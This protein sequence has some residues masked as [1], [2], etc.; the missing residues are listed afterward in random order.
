MNDHPIRRVLL[1]S[2]VGLLA[3]GSAVQ[4]QEKPAGFDPLDWPNW[5]GPEQNNTSREVGLVDS[6]NPKGGDGS[7]LL[8]KR[9]DLGSRSTPIVFRGRLYTLAR[10]EPGTP[11]E[12]E[13]VACVDAATGETVWVHRF[14]VYLS[15]VPDTRVAWSSVVADAETG[16]VYAQ[17]VCGYFCC[18][19][20]ETGKVVWERSLH[21]EFGFL[22]TYGGR[23]NFPFVMEDLVVTSAV[24][25]GWDEMAKP[26]HRFVA[27][28]KKT[29]EMV[30]FNGTRLIPYDTTYSTP[31]VTVIDGQAA[32]VFG[33]GDGQVW[34]MQPRTGKHIW[35]YPFSRRGLNV[36]P[37]VHE[38]MVYTGHSEENIEGTAMG[39]LVALDGAT[40]KQLWKL[41]EVMVGK[42]SP[43]MV[44]GQL[45]TI[46]DRAKLMAFDPT[47]GE[48]IFRKP[49]GTVQRSTPLLA[50]GKLYICDNNG[51]WYVLKPEKNGVKVLQ[52]MR[53]SHQASDG[54]PI[55]S[56]GRI[57]IPLS[58]GLFCI[59]KAD[60]EPSATPR[61]EPPQETPVDQ[62]QQVVQVQVVP[63]EVLLEPGQKQQ[64]S[65]RVYNA[66]GQRLPD[67]EAT[68]TATGAGQVSEDGMFTAAADAAH[69]AAFIEAKVGDSV[70]RARIRVVPP[71]PWR[72][73]FEDLDDMPITWIGGRVRY[74]VREVD[75]QKIAVK[76]DNIPTRP[77]HFTKLGTRS[78]LWMGPITLHDYTIQADV[79][80]QRKD[81]KMP[82]IGLINQRYVMVLLGQ[83]Q[84]LQID[85]WATQLRLHT[86]IDFPCQ[87]GAWYTMKFT[88]DV[89]DGKATLRGK[90][91]PRDQKEPADWTIVAT[92]DMPNLMG[93]PGLFGNTTDAE[94]YLDN[95][96]VTRNTGSEESQ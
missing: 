46:D 56:H 53:L 12:R 43:I 65:V 42:S 39:A 75:G 68:F 38:G 58:G 94:A 71:L 14:N 66:R 80:V 87:P 15:D 35:N 88:T 3:L 50:D 45:Y 84:E 93:A 73:D 77:G 48:M 44:G 72:W 60:Q 28:D 34:S 22:S 36:S 7:N 52:Q 6:W 33:S 16:N 92:D 49:L 83:S 23:T 95:I 31:T 85:T 20:G 51:R 11:R 47:G 90:V 40:G 63:C 10:S 9:E 89:K 57:Y 82:D 67:V 32:M 27:F 64:F 55:V 30:W 59:G 26:A 54:S 78:Q 25:I 81:S 8:W 70:G 13:M 69:T 79:Q 19:D 17:G 5:R 86:K 91:W 24:V 74:E 37:L 96:S 18:L 61:P 29:G 2:I 21:E 41:E 1:C 62:D 4:A 76:R